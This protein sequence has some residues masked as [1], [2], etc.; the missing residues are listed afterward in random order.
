[1]KFRHSQAEAA[2][3]EAVHERLIGSI[4][5]LYPNPP[6]LRYHR[7]APLIERGFGGATETQ[8]ELETLGETKINWLDMA[9][10]FLL[11]YVIGGGH[12]G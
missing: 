3:N 4:Q 6:V 1:M 5:D 11:G 9:V 2:R 7:I 10:A 8:N 12:H